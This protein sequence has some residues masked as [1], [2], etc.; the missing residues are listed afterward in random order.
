MFDLFQFGDYA[1]QMSQWKVIPE[2]SVEGQA[3]RSDAR[4]LLVRLLWKS[5][6]SLQFEYKRYS[7]MDSWCRKSFL[8]PSLGTESYHEFES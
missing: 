6:S 2:G 3:S 7:S 5:Y 1:R 8:L 4:Y